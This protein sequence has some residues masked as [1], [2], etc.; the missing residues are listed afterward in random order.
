VLFRSVELTL[1]VFNKLK[2]ILEAK[3]VEDFMNFSHLFGI[4]PDLLKDLDGRKLAQIQE[5][6]DLGVKLKIKYLSTSGLEVSER[7]VIPREIKQENN[8][9][10]LVGY[11][12]LR[13]DE[14]TFRIDGILRIELL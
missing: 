3:G 14:R 11:C 12:C 9:S 4:Q 1:E 6:I 2:E 13:K 8:R 7:E 10:Y 5:A